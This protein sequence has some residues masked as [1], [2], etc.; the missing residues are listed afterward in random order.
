MP[1]GQ[2]MKYTKYIL[3]LVILMG[4]SCFS[5]S[6]RDSIVLIGVGDYDREVIAREIEIINSLNPK[7]VAIDIAFPEYNGDKADRRLEKAIMSGKQ[8]IIPSEISSLG[9]D[10]YDKE[11]IMVSLTCALPFYYPVNTESGFVSVEIDSGQKTIPAKFMQW[12][13]AT[14]YRYRHFSVETAMKFDSLRTNAFIKA[15]DRL[16]DIDF[17]RPKSKFKI[18]SVREVLKRNLTK[19][20]IEGKIVM[21]GFL[22]PGNQDKH[23]SPLNPNLNEPDMYGLEYLAIIVAQI[24]EYKIK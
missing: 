14:G 20:D 8:I 10:Y 17:E 18:F 6:V 22:G 12:Q 2:K 13:D 24:L 1:L 11:I 21:L 23:V 3:G 5:Q 19:A 7:V 16:V 15:H 4:Q 9:L